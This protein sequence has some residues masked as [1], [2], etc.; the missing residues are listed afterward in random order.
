MFS[1]SGGSRFGPDL[2]A[3]NFDCEM[4]RVW[5]A[6]LASV[7]RSTSVT[8]FSPSGQTELHRGLKTGPPD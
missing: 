5:A 7:S 6:K 8:S 2:L 1:G 4:L 3:A